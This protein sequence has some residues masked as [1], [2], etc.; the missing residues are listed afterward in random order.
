VDF[1]EK[2]GTKWVHISTQILDTKERCLYALM[3][4]KL[5]RNFAHK[6]LLK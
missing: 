2:V 5:S 1:Y 4:Q 3:N 6:R